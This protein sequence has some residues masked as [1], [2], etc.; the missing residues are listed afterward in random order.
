MKQNVILRLTINLDRNEQSEIAFVRA[1]LRRLNVLHARSR[2]RS[3]LA[4]LLEGAALRDELLKGRERQRYR[5][6]GSIVV[7]PKPGKSGAASAN[8]SLKLLPAPASKKLEVQTKSYDPPKIRFRIT[9]LK[10]QRFDPPS[11]IDEGNPAAVAG[12]PA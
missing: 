3:G 10:E 11:W 8:R 6:P 9:A 2:P 5:K 12:G 7:P 4:E 1:M